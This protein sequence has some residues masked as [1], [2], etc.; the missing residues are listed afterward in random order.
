MS[1][2]NADA[3][4]LEIEAHAWRVWLENGDAIVCRR[5]GNPFVPAGGRRGGDG[6]ES[7]RE[8]GETVPES[9]VPVQDA[10]ELGREAHEVGSEDNE[11]GQGDDAVDLCGSCL[12]LRLLEYGDRSKR[13]PECVVCGGHIS[14]RR[15]GTLYCRESCRKAAYRGR[16]RDK[17]EDVGTTRH[18]DNPSDSGDDIALERKGG[19]PMREEASAT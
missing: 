2:S 9:E 13:L 11:V 16:V 18:N 1:K 14:G 4:I 19:Q 7:V 6:G 17:I 12:P 3:E 10:H 15:D 5:C 8:Y